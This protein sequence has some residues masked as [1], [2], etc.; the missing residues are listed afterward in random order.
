MDDQPLVVVLGDSLFMEGIAVGLAD[1]PHLEL[2]HLNDNI[3][4]I[5]QAGRCART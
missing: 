4:N 1:C 3:S 5:W 2:T